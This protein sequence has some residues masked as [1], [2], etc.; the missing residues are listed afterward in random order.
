MLYV[1]P[2]T[3]RGDRKQQDIHTLDQ[4]RRRKLRTNR[5]DALREQVI[6]QSLGIAV[7]LVEVLHQVL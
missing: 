4:L 5:G 2:H 7:K 1:S 6:F 3:L